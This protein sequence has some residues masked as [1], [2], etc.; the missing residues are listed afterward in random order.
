[1][2]WS[3]TVDLCVVKKITGWKQRLTL[4]MERSIRRELCSWSRSFTKRSLCWKEKGKRFCS[5]SRV[6]ECLSLS[7]YVCSLVA[8]RRVE[9]FWSE[10]CVETETQFL[11]KYQIIT[12]KYHQRSERDFAGSMTHDWW[13]K[14]YFCVGGT[15][16]FYCH[17]TNKSI[18]LQCNT[19]CVMC[20]NDILSYD[21]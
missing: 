7:G 15:V 13:L 1:M 19:K 17:T 3:Y 18:N 5:D 12:A 20:K 14:M 16:L 21:L 8:W 4:Y 6:F 11:C 2:D 9:M 10:K